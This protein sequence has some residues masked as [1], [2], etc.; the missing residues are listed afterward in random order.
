MFH[1]NL[2]KYVRL[3]II[4][5]RFIQRWRTFVSTTKDPAISLGVTKL[6]CALGY[7]FDLQYNLRSQLK[8]GSQIKG[9]S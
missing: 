7:V 3:F 9:L 4:K 2:W 5:G 6:V 8:D 1:D